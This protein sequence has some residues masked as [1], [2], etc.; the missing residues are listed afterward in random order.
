M[1]KKF[2]L[3]TAVLLLSVSQGLCLEIGG[4]ELPDKF[5][6][7]DTELILNG[8]GLRKKF[9]F[10]V[11]GI[12]LY[13]KTKSQENKKTIDADETMMLRMQWRR[14]VPPSKINEVFFDSF[15]AVVKAPEQ[16]SYGPESNYGP[17]TKEI[18]TFMSWISDKETTKKTSWIF[19]YSP[20]KGTEVYINDGNIEKLAGVI[21]GIDFKKALFSIWL[22]ND[23]PVGKKLM[24]KL[25]GL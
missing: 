9:G 1:L 21:P 7:G 23:A 2:I 5:K 8:A 24:K 18:V 14:G 11:Y 13:I 16:I 4:I 15:A 19:I 3:A 22:A 12:G 25:M 6:A 10:K 17:L 20:E